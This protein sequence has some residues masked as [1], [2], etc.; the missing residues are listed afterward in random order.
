MKRYQILR[1]AAKYATLTIGGIL[2]YLLVAKYALAERSYFAVGGEAFF[3][4]LPVLY[5]IITTMIRD[6]IRDIKDKKK[7]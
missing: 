4:L 1:V 7:H 6:S 5:Y 2:L 3:L